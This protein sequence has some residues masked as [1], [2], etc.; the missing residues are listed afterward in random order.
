[1]I[2]PTSVSFFLFLGIFSLSGCAETQKA[3]GENSEMARMS[4][5][6][7]QEEATFCRMSARIDEESGTI[8]ALGDDESVPPSAGQPDHLA[9]AAQDDPESDQAIPPCPEFE[10]SK[11]LGASVG[12][13]V[14]SARGEGCQWWKMNSDGRAYVLGSVSEG[15]RMAANSRG[16]KIVQICGRN[17]SS[18]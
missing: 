4:A 1:M 3:E 8:V 10:V 17:S 9:L 14:A 6:S 2:S 12:P 5:S 15:R 16:E 7:D 11:F 13:D 18:R